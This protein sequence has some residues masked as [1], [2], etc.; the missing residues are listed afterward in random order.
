MD[1]SLEEYVL[2]YRAYAIIWANYYNN[3]FGDS[4]FE[5]D[6]LYQASCLALIE[7]YYKYDNSKSSPGSY[8]YLSAKYGVIKYIRKNSSLT[9]I[10]G[11]LIIAATNLSKKNEKYYRTYG[12][13]MDLEA[14][15]DYVK[16]ECYT[17]SYRVD[18][19]FIKTLL[20]IE[21]FHLK[22][23]NF[24]LDDKVDNYNL[25]GNNQNNNICIKDCLVSND[26]TENTAIKNNI[27]EQ[28]LSYLEDNFKETD[29]DIFKEI[30][31]L[32]DE[33]PKTRRQ[34][35]KKH[36]ISHQAID[37]K[38]KKM[39]VKIKQNFNN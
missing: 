27:V 39:L 10:S 23:H 33:I 2:K 15:V 13:N 36:N 32:V 3:I 11:D 14:M 20:K 24:S 19:D 8:A 12:K 34:L 30:L 17:G 9:K 31:G 1:L 25:N 37:Q 6:D 5:F 26:N 22:G 38:Y 28:I 16:K 21:A 18:N 35:S 4:Y 7:G 29:I